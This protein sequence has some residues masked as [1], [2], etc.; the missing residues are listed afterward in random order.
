MIL[1]FI[2]VNKKNTKAHEPVTGDEDKPIRSFVKALSWRIIGT[3]DTVI[4]S[5]IL[6]G[7]LAIAFSIGSVEIVTKMLLYFFQ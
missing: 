5:W 3:I 6:T 2:L 4:I 7:N 1:D